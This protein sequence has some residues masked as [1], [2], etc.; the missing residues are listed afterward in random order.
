MLDSLLFDVVL[1]SKQ[2]SICNTSLFTPYEH[3]GIASQVKTSTV[4]KFVRIIIITCT[5][6]TVSLC[7]CYVE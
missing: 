2:F 7:V 6:I 1:N 4:I 3:G 5:C